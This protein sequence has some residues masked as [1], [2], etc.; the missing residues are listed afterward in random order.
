MADSI[1]VDATAGLVQIQGRDYS[2]L[3]I[4]STYQDAFRN[5]TSSEIANYIASRHGFG[6]NISV[7]YTMVGSYQCGEYN[8][9]LLNSHSHL[10]HEWALL[11][12]LAKREGFELFIN[13]TTLVFAPQSA[14]HQSH[15][16]LAIENVIGARFHVRC[17]L[18]D[19]TTLTVKSWNSWMNQLSTYSET[20][21]DDQSTSAINGLSS[22]L[23]FEIAVV[24]PNLTSHGAEQIAKQHIN[25]LNEQA[26]NVEVIAPGE[27][28]LKPLDIIS[29]SGSNSSFDVDYVVRSVRRHFSSNTGFIEYINGYTLEANPPSSPEPAA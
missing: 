28:Y 15:S 16:E 18:S 5:Q 7:T 29:I 20:K 22:D 2:S 3:L 9:L 8:N 19:Q 21:S 24:M 27:L 6:T 1:I 12:F 26:L 11:V 13:G 10:T 17:P 25:T 23:G 14:L 4:N